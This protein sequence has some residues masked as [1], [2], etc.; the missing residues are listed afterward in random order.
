MES[1]IRNLEKPHRRLNLLTG[2][3]ILVSPHRTKRPWQGKQEQQ[4]ID[5]RKNYDPKCYLCPGNERAG[6]EKNP[7]YEKTYVFTND[8]A[9]LLPDTPDFSIE[10]NN[11]FKLQSVKGTS[12]VICFSPSH[13]LTLAEMEVS[14]I[15]KVIEMWSQQFA[16][17]SKIY[18][19]VQI[20]ENKGDIMGCSNPHPHGQIWAS[21]QIPNEATKEDK[22]QKEYYTENGNILLIDYLEKELELDERVILTNKHWVVLVPFWATWPYETLLLPRRHITKI[23]QITDDEKNTLAEIMSKFLIKY[24]NLFETIFPY[25]MGWHNAPNCEGCNEHWQLHA[26]F[27]PPLLRS[28]TVKKFMVGYEMLAEAQR[29]ITAEQAAQK[30]K[31][32]P[33]IHFSKK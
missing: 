24:D 16:E 7:N 26:H 25:T 23:N 2:E 30:L 27:Y 8:F 31:K 21:N 9:A 4:F 10:K 33:E 18:K 20:F 5:N 11:L 22:Q 13:N 15:K 14:D 6:G 12:R 19:W 1:E 32:L 17:L 29:D 3:W 28:A